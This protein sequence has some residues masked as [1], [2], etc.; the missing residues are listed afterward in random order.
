[1]GLCVDTE[2]SHLLRNTHTHTIDHMISWTVN[3][4]SVRVVLIRGEFAKVDSETRNSMCVC[5]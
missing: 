1:M 3:V 4:Y 5:L 2:G